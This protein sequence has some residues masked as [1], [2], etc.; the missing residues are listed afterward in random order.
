M[1]Y[2]TF[3]LWLRLRTLRLCER[4]DWELYTKMANG[5]MMMSTWKS[6]AIYVGMLCFS[7]FS[8]SCFTIPKVLWFYSNFHAMPKELQV[9]PNDSDDIGHSGRVLEF[10]FKFYFKDFFI[11]ASFEFLFFTLICF[12]VVFFLYFW[13]HL[14]ITNW[15][16]RRV[17]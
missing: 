4:L 3:T 6:I 14:Y 11:K 13:H 10:Y 16:K 17:F 12:F 15:H 7:F 9:E 5:R 2:V 1:D 8:Y